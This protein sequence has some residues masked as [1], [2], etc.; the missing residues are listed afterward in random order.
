MISS[1]HLTPTGPRP[2]A[3]SHDV[4]QLLLNTDCKGQTLQPG[5]GYQLQ[6]Q[7]QIPTGLGIQQFNITY[8]LC[9]AIIFAHWLSGQKTWLFMDTNTITTSNSS[10]NY[11][12]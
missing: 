5:L 4:H 2:A 9:S 7:P 10:C 12:T 3:I 1:L 8:P 6:N 11:P